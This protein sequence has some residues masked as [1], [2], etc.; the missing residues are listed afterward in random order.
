MLRKKIWILTSFPRSIREKE[1]CVKN[2][3]ELAKHLNSAL[4]GRVGPNDALPS[5]IIDDFNP[6]G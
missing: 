3:H 2:F 5:Q 4:L 1:S 6:Q